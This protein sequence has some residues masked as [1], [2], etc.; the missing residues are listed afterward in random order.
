M[1]FRTKKIGAFL[2]AI[3]AVMVLTVTLTACFNGDTVIKFNSNGGSPIEDLVITGEEES[4]TLP[5]PT[6]EGYEF[7]GWYSDRSLNNRVDDVLTG[8]DIPTASDTFYAKWTEIKVTITF[9]VQGN[10][11][12]TKTVSY[13]S[14]IKIEDY[15]S[16]DN[17]PD[18]EWT[19]G[20]FTASYDRTV[21][22][23]I[24][25]EASNPKYSVTYYALN[26]NKEYVEYLKFIDYPDVSIVL[27]TRKI[28]VLAV[29]GR[30]RRGG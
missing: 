17:Y 27:P 2:C 30:T 21:A 13:G 25:K 3:L 4:I 9:T 1:T 15:P 24:K 6:K 28:I 23:T 11:V 29:F 19:T 26:E 16:L 10:I 20:A 12:G 18:Y 8:E 22:A 5:I 7:G 14:S